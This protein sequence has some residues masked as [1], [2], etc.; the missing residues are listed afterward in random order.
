MD[1]HALCVS[2]LPGVFSAKKVFLKHGLPNE[3]YTGGS[4]DVIEGEWMS[5][6]DIPF[7]DDEK[8]GCGAEN[9]VRVPVAIAVNDVG[10]AIHAWGYA[11]D[12]AAFAANGLGIVRCKCHLSATTRTDAPDDRFVGIDLNDIGSETG[13]GL[14][15]G[16]RRAASDFHHGDNR[17]HADNDAKNR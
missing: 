7:A 2:S 4:A 11:A 8:I 17:G 1:I 9:V 3:T 15:D 14:F 12:R 6:N 13:D 5:L 10:P 16:G